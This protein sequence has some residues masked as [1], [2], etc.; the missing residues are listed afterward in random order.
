MTVN[1]FDFMTPAQ[2]ADVQARTASIEVTDA[3]QA[4]L[5]SGKR[6]YMP[7]GVYLT[8]TLEIPGVKGLELVG[9]GPERTILQAKNQDQIVLRKEQVPG[10]VQFGYIGHFSIKAHS[11]GST[12]PAFDCSGFRAVTFAHVSGLSNGSSGFDSLF[13]VSAS[14]YVT[15]GCTWMLPILAEQAGWTHAFKFNN[16]GGGS[17]DN[18]NA[19]TIISP[20]IYSNSGLAYGIDAARSASLKVLGGLIEGNAGATAIRTGN[21][22]LIEGMFLEANGADIEFGLLPD[23]VGN[24]G[25][26]RNC[27]FSSPHTIDLVGVTAN[28]WYGNTEAGLQTIINNNGTNAI[29]KQIAAALQPPTLSRILGGTGTLTLAAA[30]LVSPT[31]LTGKATYCLTALWTADAANTQTEFSITPPTGWGVSAMSGGTV[32]NASG[33]PGKFSVTSNAAWVHN[34]FADEHTLTLYVTL[35]SL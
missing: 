31:D 17:V 2:V 29:Q 18:A 28:E 27:Y 3:L 6:V 19:N 7:E 23:G 15:Y 4:A 11:G 34:A 21:T 35:V 12:G 33:E 13:D 16:R 20:W 10:V 5:N 24:G 25:T 26:I 22:T 9:S 30:S 14:P 8:D 32:R 1:A